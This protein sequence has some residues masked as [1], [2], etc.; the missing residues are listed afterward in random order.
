M[1]MTDKGR[2]QAV[3]HCRDEA[4]LIQYFVLFINN[5]Q[6]KLNMSPFFKLKTYLEYV[7]G[8]PSPTTLLRHSHWTCSRKA[9]RC[10]C[11]QVF[12]ALL[13]L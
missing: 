7:S 13:D 6:N 4:T 11:L 2:E 9:L 3:H 10:S 1:T 5:K 8:T 12:P